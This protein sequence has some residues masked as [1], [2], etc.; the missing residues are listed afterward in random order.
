MPSIGTYTR[1]ITYCVL[2]YIFWLTLQVTK[3]HGSHSLQVIFWRVF[4]C[5]VYLWR[6]SRIYLMFEY[7]FADTTS[8]E[9]FL[10]IHSFICLCKITAGIKIVF[11]NVMQKLGF[12]QL[13]VAF[14]FCRVHFW[15]TVFQPN[16]T[17][18][19]LSRPLLCNASY[20]HANTHTQTHTG[21]CITPI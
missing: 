17:L 16:V 10:N 8:K 20:A 2:C 4:Q 18:C 14:V 11:A 12:A 6:V 3:Y 9:Y 15:A 7:L 19:N 13:C 5:H 1:I 21:V